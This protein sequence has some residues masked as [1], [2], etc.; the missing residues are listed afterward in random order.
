MERNCGRVEWW[1]LNWN[2]SAIEF[3]ESLKARPMNEFTVFRLSSAG[4]RSLAGDG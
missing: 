4:L 2:R 1:V 3:Y